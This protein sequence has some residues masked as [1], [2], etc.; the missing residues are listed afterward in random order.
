MYTYFVLTVRRVDG[1]VQSGTIQGVVTHAVYW[2]RSLPATEH[3]RRLADNRQHA[4]RR[5]LLCTVRR[6]LHHAH[7]VIR[8][9]KKT[10]SRKGYTLFVHPSLLIREKQYATPLAYLFLPYRYTVTLLEIVFS[11]MYVRSIY[12][13]NYYLLTYLFTY[14]RTYLLTYVLLHSII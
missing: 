7:P 3:N 5:Y 2:L 9:L 8:H 11:C 12:A 10:L 4:H 6:L 1:T 14:L 13:L